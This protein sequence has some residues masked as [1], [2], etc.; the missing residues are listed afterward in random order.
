MGPA[1]LF[2]LM[3]EK[4]GV[5]GYD[6]VTSTVPYFRH[7]MTEISKIRT[8]LRSRRVHEHE[9]LIAIEYAVAHRKVITE[10]WQV[11]NLVPEALAEHHRNVRSQARA[12]A[13]VDATAL[14]AEAYHAGHGT[15]AARLLNAE[16]SELPTVVAEY[17]ERRDR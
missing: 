11:F 9:L 13:S 1:E 15:W 12:A 8:M 17:R 7:R 4:F 16:P 10:T 6:D 5:G 3:A 2:D 14:A